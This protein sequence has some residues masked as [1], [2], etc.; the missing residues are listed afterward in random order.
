M[1][2]GREI[3]V[4]CLEHRRTL[5]VFVPGSDPTICSLSAYLGSPT[6]ENL[7]EGLGLPHCQPARDPCLPL[8]PSSGEA[9]TSRPHEEEGPCLLLPGTALDSLSTCP[10]PFTQITIHMSPLRKLRL[11]GVQNLT[12]GTGPGAYWG[13]Q[14]WLFCRFCVSLSFSHCFPPLLEP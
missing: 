9:L 4:E 14:A 11:G 3:K 5:S 1:Q 6:P 2:F 12:W 7:S 8:K 13:P 10:K